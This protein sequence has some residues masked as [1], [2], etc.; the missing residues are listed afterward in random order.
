MDIAAT[1]PETID[2]A[3]RRLR[4]GSLT[5]ERLTEGYLDRIHQLQPKLNAFITVTDELALDMARHLDAELRVGKDRG[6]LHG[7]PIAYKDNIDTRGIPTTAGAEFFRNRVPDHDAAIV[8]RLTDA[9]MVMLGKLNMSEFASGS[10]G[11]NVFFG[12]VHNPWDLTRAPGGSSSGTG[13]AVAAGMTLTGIGTDAGGSIRQ[14]ASRCGIFGLRPTFG[15]VNLTGVWPRTRTLG[16]GGPM[17]RCVRDAALMMNA[18]AGSDDDFAEDF[19]LQLDR[20]VA[21]LRLGIIE[22]YTFNDIDPE[23]EQVLRSAVEVLAQLGAEIVTVRIPELTGALE[24]SSL[25]S[26]VL[27]YE[28]NEILG[29]QYRNADKSLFGPAVHSDLQRGAQVLP[30]TY[31]RILK[32]RPAQS[33]TVKKVFEKV[34]A[35]LAPVLPNVT[36]LQSAGPEVWARGRQFNLPFSFIGVPSVSVP[37]G[38][39]LDMPVGLQIAANARQEALL[40]RIAAAFEAA[41]DYHRRRPPSI[42]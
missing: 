13:A 41:T 39:A 8:R 23:I 38:F 33:A 2:E 25:F 17:T 37:C 10:S 40:L 26:N 27:L 21:G 30:E 36:P 35:L 5:V 11:V 1:L 7:I 9:G 6:P 22:G 32:E 14:P 29:P 15:R 12:N 18:L 19:T 4:D 16:A 20:G 31:R 34:D 24:Y 28:F 42:V 3:A